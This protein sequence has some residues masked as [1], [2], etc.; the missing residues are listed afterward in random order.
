MFNWFQDLRMTLLFVSPVEFV[1]Q[2]KFL[3]QINRATLLKGQVP[4][5]GISSSSTSLLST[6]IRTDEFKLKAFTMAIKRTRR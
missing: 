4:P 2:L 1:Q 6:A 3:K 5:C